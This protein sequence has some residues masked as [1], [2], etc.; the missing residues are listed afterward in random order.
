[1]P[2]KAIPD[3]Y[4]TATPYIIVNSASEAGMALVTHSGFEGGVKLL[5]CVPQFVLRNFV[6]G[7]SKQIYVFDKTTGKSF[8]TAVR[9]IG[10]VRRAEHPPIP[11][12]YRRNTSAT[13]TRRGSSV[14]HSI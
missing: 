4:R 10:S 8:K 13:G 14:S 6:S 11:R 2:R 3:A 12:R 9:N 1:M 5:A 7:R